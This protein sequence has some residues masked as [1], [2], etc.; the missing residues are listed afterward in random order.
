MY[1]NGRSSNIIQIIEPFHFITNNAI[2]YVKPHITFVSLYLNID[3]FKC[4][5]FARFISKQVGPSIA[6]VSKC[7]HDLGQAYQIN[8]VGE[9]LVYNSTIG[10]K[11][12]SKFA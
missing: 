6:A 2:W 8:N 10:P 9:Y 11:T 4:Y 5:I 1:K 3:V 12:M 7:K